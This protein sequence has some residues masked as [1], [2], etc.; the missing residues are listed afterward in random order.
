MDKTIIVVTGHRPDKL[1]GYSEV[2]QDR[3][4]SFAHKIFKRIR[5]FDHVITG[6]ALGWD[7]AVAQACLDLK[8][9][10]HTYIPFVG[11]EKMWPQPSQAKY[12]HL[13]ENAAKT[14]VVCSGDFAPWKMQDRNKAMVDRATYMIALWN[15]STGGTKNCVTYARDKA[16]NIRGIYNAW[17][18]FEEFCGEKRIAA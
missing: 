3:V 1:G 10:Y 4:Y 2:A 17:G 13:V 6:M 9:P 18:E 14:V 7:T 8:I 15:G 11:Q 12:R 5:G 16:D